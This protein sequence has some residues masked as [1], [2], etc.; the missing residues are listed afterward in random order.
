[1][2]I[3]AWTT[4]WEVAQHFAIE[5]S[6]ELL[7]VA[8]HKLYL[9]IAPGRHGMSSVDLPSPGGERHETSRVYGT[10]NVVSC[11]HRILAREVLP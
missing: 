8:I 4:R 5:F 2:D 7:A 1:M 10:T 6:R 3:K 9:D 11:E